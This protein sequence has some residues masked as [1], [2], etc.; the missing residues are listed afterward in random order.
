MRPCAEEN[1]IQGNSVS[2]GAGWTYE[3]EEMQ[4]RTASNPPNAPDTVAAEKKTAA[5]IPNSERLYQL[6]VPRIV[7]S[8]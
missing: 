4:M 5:R 2:F 3:I 6:H 1:Q 8:Q 7:Y